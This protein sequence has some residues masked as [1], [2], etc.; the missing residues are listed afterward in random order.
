MTTT[1][2]KSTVPCG[3]VAAKRIGMYGL[4]D[5]KANC[6]LNG[7]WLASSRAHGMC[8]DGRV[9]VLPS[10]P[11]KWGEPYKKKSS[12]NEACQATMKR[13]QQNRRR[14]NAAGRARSNA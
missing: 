13:N 8:S 6:F 14:I 7:S 2:G 10:H 4:Q 5:P 1:G 12:K 11:Q 9:F 3:K